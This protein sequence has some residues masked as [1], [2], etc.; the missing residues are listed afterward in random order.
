MDAVVL[1]EVLALAG[2]DVPGLEADGW[3]PPVQGAVGHAVGVRDASGSPL[4]LKIYPVAGPDR[5]DTE[6]LAQRLLADVPGPRVPRPVTYGDV[7]RFPGVS[8]LVMTRL[9]GTRWAD[10]RASMDAAGTTRLTREVGRALQGLHAVRG[11]WY[12]DLV[13]GGTRWPSAWARA[14]ARSD[15]L[16]D[17]YVRTGGPSGLTGRIRRFVAGCQAALALCP[18]PVLCHNDVNDG[19]LLIS[20]TPDPRLSGVDLERA[21]WDDPLNDLAKTRLHIRHHRPADTAALIE[22]YG[23]DGTDAHRRLDA[24]EVLHAL[25]ERLWVA[26]DR[27]AG[28]RHSVDALDAFLAA[29]T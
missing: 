14:A 11:R 13:D 15:E 12:G 23:V 2:R 1:A 20:A 8:F 22:A 27:P 25:E 19:N 17:R 10:R 26:Q 9:D 18:G 7:D 21:S 5:R 6:V 28:W 29:R 3:T 16:L 24:Y 4:V